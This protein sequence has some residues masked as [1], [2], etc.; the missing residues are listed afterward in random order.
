MACLAVPRWAQ[1][2]ADGRPYADLAAL[3]AGAEAA[4]AELTDDGADGR[5]RPPP[6]DRRARR[7]AD[8][9][10]AFSAREQAGVEPDDAI[11]A[12]STAGNLEY[13]RRFGRVFLIRAAGRDGAEILAELR[14]QVGQR[15]EGRAGGDG[16]RSC[17]RSPSSG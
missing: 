15:R 12:R 17:A 6:A 3:T 14:A 8:H 7:V 11:S 13:E 10:A 2:V 16:R 4:A 1:E 9:D 5:A